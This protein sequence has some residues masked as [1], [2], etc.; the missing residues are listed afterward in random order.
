M[1][2]VQVLVPCYNYAR[3]LEQC[4]KSVL[5]QEGVEVDVLIIDDCSLDHTPEVCKALTANDSR[6]RV[7]R[8]EKNRG[9]IATYN[10]GIDQI[11]GDY[12]VLL[13]ADDCLA[14][15]ALSRATSLMQANPNVGMT[16]GKAISF[17]T[18]QL[19]KAH[20]ISTGISIWAG[21]H[22]IRQVCRS[23]KNFINCPEVVVRS[24]VQ[25]QLGGYD[26]SLPHSGDMEMWLR[27][28][29]VSDIGRVNGADQA[30]YRIHPQSM[31]RTVHSGFLFDLSGRRDAF[32]SAF[33]KEGAKLPARDEL[34]RL[35]KQALASDCDPACS[36]AWRSC[37]G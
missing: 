23:G 1:V 13:S 6:I 24:S 14:P 22:W 11:N 32:H 35:S 4:V 5:D 15:G 27:I 8:H 7:I 9:H 25:R 30:F 28:A 36:R 3:Y 12:F 29:A 19:P 17:A 33:L 2:T 21:E 16:Y 34:H 10:E 20:T 31:Q 18:G 26:P 37:Y